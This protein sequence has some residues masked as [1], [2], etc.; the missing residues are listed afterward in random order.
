MS[1]GLKT[2]GGNSE[3]AIRHHLQVQE[4]GSG[5]TSETGKM[6]VAS[7]PIKS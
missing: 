4:R 3:M 5:S 6:Q 1:F 7:D 2:F